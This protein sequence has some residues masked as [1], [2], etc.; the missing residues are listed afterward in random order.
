M[1]F[2]RLTCEVVQ[3]INELPKKKIATIFP[4]LRLTCKGVLVELINEL[5][6]KNCKNFSSP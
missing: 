4:A 5:P 2:H 3:L 1:D 6:K